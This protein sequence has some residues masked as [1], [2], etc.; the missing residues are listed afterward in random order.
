MTDHAV[1][2]M[3]LTEILDDMADT[4]IYTDATTGEMGS[5]PNRE[6]AQ[7]QRIINDFRE[8]NPWTLAKGYC[9]RAEQLAL[10]V[11]E[12]EAMIPQASQV[13]HRRN[14]ELQR[15]LDASLVR[16]AQLDQLLSGK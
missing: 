3:Y 9:T 10:R 4:A 1:I 13:L 11:Q 14:A 6:K 16:E 7:L 15:Q 8:R 12:L 2:V 5:Q